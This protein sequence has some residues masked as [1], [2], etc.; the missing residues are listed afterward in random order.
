MQITLKNKIRIINID[1]SVVVWEQDKSS[2]GGEDATL[3]FQGDNNFV[4]YILGKAYWASGTNKSSD[5][6]LK[7]VVLYDDGTF[8]IM[9]GSVTQ[10][11]QNPKELYSDASII[12]QDKSRT[13]QLICK[14]FG[15]TKEEEHL[16]TLEMTNRV[17]WMSQSSL[18][19]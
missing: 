14:N 4:Y 6:T 9:F 13:C 7:Q 5:E 8:S 11:E 18:Q 2:I 15:T 1:N 17:Q 3:V 12:N 10:Y 19:R 16:Q